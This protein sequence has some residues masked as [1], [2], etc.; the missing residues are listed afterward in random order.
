MEEC[1]TVRLQ[2]ESRTRRTEGRSCFD[3]SVW[4]CS[5]NERR[6]YRL[7]PT[8]PSRFTTPINNLSVRRTI[9]Q[10]VILFH[11]FSDLT[12]ELFIDVGAREG[13]PSVEKEKTK[14]VQNGSCSFFFFSPLTSISSALSTERG[15]PGADKSPVICQAS[16]PRPALLFSCILLSV[17]E[18]AN[19][20]K[21]VSIWTRSSTGETHSTAGFCRRWA[22]RSDPR[23]SG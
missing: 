23:C 18:S 1:A 15:L 16:P 12:D 2:I 22:T 6:V 11:R 9:G 4:G 7:L 20:E 8:R 17:I 19:S 14:K 10:H 13:G 5:G 21:L 3:V